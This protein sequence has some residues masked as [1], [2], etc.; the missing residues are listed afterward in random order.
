MNW[1]IIIVIILVF[2]GLF[3]GLYP[4]YRKASINSNTTNFRDEIAYKDHLKALSDKLEPMREQRRP[5]GDELW[6]ASEMPEA[7]QCFVNFY[8]LGCRFTGYLGPFEEG[9]FDPQNAV[10]LACDAGCRVFVLEIDYLDSCKGEQAL[11]Y[12]QIVVRDVNGRLRIKPNSNEPLCKTAQN[13]NIRDVCQAIEDYA[14]NVSSDPV[15]IVLYFLRQP[16]GSYKSQTVLEY[17]SRVASALAPFQNRLITNVLEGGSFFRQKQEGR[18]LINKITDYNNKVLI[19]SNA[20]TNGFRETNT[21][22]PMEDLD[23][24]VNLRLNYTQTQLGCTEATS[25]GNYG[26]IETV[27]DYLII[28]KDRAEEVADNTKLRWTICLEKDPSKPVSKEEFNKVTWGYGVHCIP[29]QIFSGDK[30]DFVYSS[31]LFKNYSYIPKP[32]E[33]RYIKPPIVIPGEP[34]PN[35]NANQGQLRSPTVGGA[36]NVS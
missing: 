14:F 13:S 17:Y 22:G 1:I 4:V 9:Y 24:L 16:P 27:Q 25:Q 33:L 10:K 23:F 5:V 8:G 34:N 3:I 15:V 26:I 12:P 18:L 21:Y 32:K 29:I 2:I 36:S 28:P 19:F 31:E 11:Y 30:E 6:N 7:E 20:N 35:T